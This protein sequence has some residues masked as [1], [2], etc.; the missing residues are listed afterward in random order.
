MGWP[1]IAK[2]AAKV[3]SV[4][5]RMEII[6][7]RKG[8]PAVIVDYAHK[9]DALR[10]A[11]EAVRP[12]AQKNGGKLWVVFGCGGNRDALKRPLMGRIAAELADGVVVTDDNPRFEDAAAIRAQVMA[13]AK[14]VG[15]MVVREIG[16]RKK[17]IEETIAGAGPHDVILV[18]GKG[19]EEGQIVG[20][21]TLPFDDRVVVRG[22]VG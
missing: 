17:A 14:A 8:M 12:L 7:G 3:T 22:V 5:G 20:G 16:D 10:R 4:P 19:H 2:A 15:A 6:A 9:P 13:G 1:D 21:E 18:A 11:L